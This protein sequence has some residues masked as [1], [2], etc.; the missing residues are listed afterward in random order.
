[1]EPFQPVKHVIDFYELNDFY[2]RYTHCRPTSFLSYTYIEHY[3][4][5]TGTCRILMVPDLNLG[6]LHQRIHLV[7][8][9]PGKCRLIPQIR[10]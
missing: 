9:L 2:E 3:E 4:V 1:M 8:S 6:R 5:L 10:S 7:S